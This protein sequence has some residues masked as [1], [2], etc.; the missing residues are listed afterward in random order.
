QSR[1]VFGIPEGWTGY[2]L[3]V[4][5]AHWAGEP[6]AIVAAVERYVAEDALELVDIEYEL[7]EPVLDARAAANGGPIVLEGKDTNIAYQRTFTFGDTETA[8]READLVVQEDLRWNRTSGNPI[9]TC[10]CLAQWDPYSQMLTLRGSHRSP[11]LILPAVV[12]S[13]GIPSSQVR[14]VQSPLGGSFGVKTFAR[15]VILLSLLAKR[16]RGPC[17]K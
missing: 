15:Y 3:A 13:L 2:A 6:V 4:E 9:E 17:G 12:A 10:V 11:H 8:F 7:L 1:P 5:K 14:I 16:L